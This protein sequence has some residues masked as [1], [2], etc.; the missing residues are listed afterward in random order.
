[1]ELEG[2][3]PGRP[4]IPRDGDG[5]DGHRRA[6]V[7]AD[8]LAVAVCRPAGGE[9][10]VQGV[11]RD[12]RVL[13]AT[14]GDR[15]HRGGAHRRR[16]ARVDGDLGDAVPPAQER[17]AVPL[18]VADDADVAS[19]DGGE[20]VALG[21]QRPPAAATGEH[22]GPGRAVE[23]D[24]ELE[25][26]LPGRP[27][28]PRDGDGSDGHRR[29]EV[30]ADPLAVA[31]CRPAGGEVAVQGVLR[32][33]GV[34]IRARH[35]RGCRERREISSDGN[36]RGSAT[37]QLG[38]GEIARARQRQDGAGRKR[39]FHESQSIGQFELERHGL[40]TPQGRQ[41]VMS[42]TQRYWVWDPPGM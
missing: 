33:V 36:S 25:G 14:R 26:R 2:R 42:S 18:T 35:D 23:G 34:L 20:I 27:L 37:V 24:V 4:L 8:P 10:A 1:M 38:I 11:P 41:T 39:R 28:I 21:L 13:I 7:V 40:V 9:V 5:S 12:V 22:R 29:A 3:L 16:G 32:D 30:V 31:V 6:E 19:R 17:G 15:G